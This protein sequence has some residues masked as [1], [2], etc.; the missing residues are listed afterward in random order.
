MFQKTT[1]KNG[2]RVLTSSIPGAFSVG[3]SVLV[4]A[5]SR[6]ENSENNGISHFLEHML[7]RG[8]KKR[9]SEEK[10]AN[11][12]E[13]IGG[14]ISAWTGKEAVC[15]W[16][17]VPKEKTKIGFEIISDMIFNSKLD[18][19]EIEKEKGTVIQEIN[20]R[21]DMPDGCSWELVY[22]T[23][24][25]GYPL[26]QS[27]L[28]TKE[29]IKNLSREAIIEY[30]NYLYL[31]GNMVVSAAGDIEH[32][33]LVGFAEEFFG[34]KAVSKKIKFLSIKETQKEPRIA[35]EFRETKQ[36][37]LALGIKAFHNNH[38]DKSVLRVINSL[39]GIG[40]SSR[41]YL[42]IRSK[43]GLA[44]VIGSSV[45]YFQDTGS[46]II[47]TGV[48]NEKTELAVKEIIKELKRLKTESVKSSE[49]EKAKEKLKGRL[50]FKIESPAE[51]AD[52]LGL[53]ELLQPKVLS[54]KEI[55]AKI[56]AVTPQDIKRVSNDLFKSQRLNLAIVGP[57]NDKTNLQD[58]LK[59]ID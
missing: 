42:N 54:L 46:L 47:I 7:F 53:Q 57:H 1:L 49:L 30:M 35:L 50:L 40:C 8:T 5:G 32:K 10:I 21:R 29:N 19:I 12:I 36:T 38:P 56:N 59:K 45:D 3:I 22:K 37:H 26:G 6:Y 16:V 23:M 15:Y 39:L 4:G 27:V 24:W 33:K 48:K 43:K 11:S 44:Y 58:I 13:G 18:V 28:G 34:K 51:R 2:L 14:I 55:L 41:L 17:K 9:P 25:S 52:W 31:P 20:R